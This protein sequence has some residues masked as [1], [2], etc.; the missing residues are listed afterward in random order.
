MKSGTTLSLKASGFDP[1]LVKTYQGLGAK[2]DNGP[3]V[4]DVTAENVVTVETFLS[5]AGFDMDKAVKDMLDGLKNPYEI[6]WQ[7]GS[8]DIDP[9]EAPYG[10]ILAQWPRYADDWQRQGKADEFRYMRNGERVYGVKTGRQAFRWP[11]RGDSAQ[12]TLTIARDA[13]FNVPADLWNKLIDLGTEYETSIAG[14]YE[15]RNGSLVVPEPFQSKLRDFQRAG[16]AYTLAKKRVIIADDLG[17]GKTIETLA[18][19]EAAN[20][21]PALV[22]VKATARK[23]WERQCHAWVPGRK[24]YVVNGSDMM[25]VLAATY[26]D[27]II[28]SYAMMDKMDDVV[29]VLKQRGMKAIVGDESHH[30]KTWNTDQT[31]A[32]YRASR[33]VDYR[34]MLSA[35]PM[36]NGPWELVSQVRILDQE[37]AIGGRRWFQKHIVEGNFES[38]D[39]EYLRQQ[40]QARCF[41]R[42]TKEAVTDQLPGIVSVRRE[43]ELANQDDYEKAQQ[44]FLEWYMTNCA[45]DDDFAAAL[46][47]LP[48][49]QQ[50]QLWKERIAQQERSWRGVSSGSTNLLAQM[51]KLRHACEIGKVQSAL[52]AVGESGDKTVVFGWHRDVNTALA[53]D[54]DCPLL[55]GGDSIKVQDAQ[56]RRFQEDDDTTRIVVSLAAGG[57]SLD[58][59]AGARAVF[60]GPDWSP[61]KITQAIG[62][63]RRIGSQHENCEIVT[64]HAPGT[65]D[66]SIETV[67]QRKL[68]GINAVLSGAAAPL[69]EGDL[70]RE[71]AEELVHRKGVT[72]IFRYMG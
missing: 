31:Q 44:G 58:M 62:R 14:S 45:S 66:D 12:R 25:N 59:Q 29:S 15:V 35:T 46:V 65:V 20:A 21:Y 4:L 48:K 26:A 61:G 7:T 56:V 42:R 69:N 53:R 68:P 43:V 9:D 41:L 1:K 19:L 2:F 16:V 24:V 39:M 18:T 72:N 10:W 70:A 32:V 38:D 52:D 5:T 17:L 64:L 54:L 60:T 22:V 27:I 34:L 57:E 49:S 36:P 6:F 63:L 23:Q 33:N 50:E 3:W 55:I 67:Y 8:N 40:L 71:V 51:S 11:L 37:S 13:N 28:V 30:L 47:N